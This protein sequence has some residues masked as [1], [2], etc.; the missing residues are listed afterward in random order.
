MA[1]LG[2]SSFTYLHGVTQPRIDSWKLAR[3]WTNQSTAWMTRYL[4]RSY[5]LVDPRAT[6][7]GQSTLPKLWEQSSERG[8]SVAADAFLD[9][10][11]A[12]GIG[13]GMVMGFP[14]GLGLRALFLFNATEPVI[15]AARRQSVI[16]DFGTY[17]LFATAVHALYVA[18][19]P[20]S[21]L[22]ETKARSLSPD[23]AGMLQLLTVGVTP[24]EIACITGIAGA[25]VAR[26]ANELRTRLGLSEHF[27]P[28]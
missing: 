26:V 16:D 2:F 23:D 27:L 21:S 28:C 3:G 4:E 11:L 8:I 15:S 14:L 17:Y 10:A 19:I 6:H 25:V 12:H 24:A 7:G 9:D 22:S 20:A 18:G 1:D 5:F 13:S